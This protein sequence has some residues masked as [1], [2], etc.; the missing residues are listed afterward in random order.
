MDQLITIII[1]SGIFLLGLS[2]LN[3][4]KD[5]KIKSKY[6]KCAACGNSLI[7]DENNTI[8]FD[9]II[10]PKCTKI[11][12]KTNALTPQA[13]NMGKSGFKFTKSEIVKNEI[14]I[15]KNLHKGKLV[16]DKDSKNN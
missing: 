15:Y 2:I 7:E 14:E 1:I 11:A 12:L 6:D 13:K 4:L 16:N 8:L 10:C 3:S 5:E 9:G